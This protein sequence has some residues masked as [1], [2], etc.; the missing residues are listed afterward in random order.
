M[1]QVMEKIKEK[2]KIKDSMKFKRNKFSNPSGT[3][4]KDLLLS[5]NF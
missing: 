1:S 2:G 5:E 4:K 3:L